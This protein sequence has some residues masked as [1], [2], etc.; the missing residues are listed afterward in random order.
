[1]IEVLKNPQTQLYTQ[2]KEFIK[3]NDFTWFWHENSTFESTKIDGNDNIPF[4]AHTFLERAELD[5]NKNCF[6]VVKSQLTETASAVFQ[7]ILNF[8]NIEYSCFLRMGTNC[9]HPFKKILKTIP[10]VDHHYVKHKN[11][12]IYLDNSDGDTIVENKSSSPKEDKV[13][14]FSG[15]HYHIT[16]TEKRRIVLVATFM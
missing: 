10:H 6:P 12:L 5:T 11:I 7:E 2:L 15:S 14:I 16:P 9:V 4:Y 3:S 8:N 1:M 13:I